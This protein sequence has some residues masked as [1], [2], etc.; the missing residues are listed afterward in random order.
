MRMCICAKL[1]KKLSLH[2]IQT[3][4]CPPERAADRRHPASLP[5]KA[6]GKAFVLVPFSVFFYPDF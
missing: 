1:K 3:F 2:S 5:M 6:M 4:L